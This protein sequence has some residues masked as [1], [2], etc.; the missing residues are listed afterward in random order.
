[1]ADENTYDEGDF[2]GDMEDEDMAHVSILN[3]EEEIVDIE[4]GEEIPLVPCHF[5][6]SNQPSRESISFYPIYLPCNSST[7]YL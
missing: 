6:S 4:I 1:M 7:L 5:C 2:E 3:V